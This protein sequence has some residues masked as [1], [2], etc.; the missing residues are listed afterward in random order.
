MIANVC[1]TPIS[2]VSSDTLP[3]T[4]RWLFEKPFH[5][6][7]TEVALWLR[8]DTEHEGSKAPVGCINYL[9]KK[10]SLIALVVPAWLKWRGREQ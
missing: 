9:R 3:G 4:N 7:K 2:I 1:K 6:L 10:A 8:S 5:G